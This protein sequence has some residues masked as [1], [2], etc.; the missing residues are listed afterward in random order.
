[1]NADDSPLP[2]DEMSQP[3]D[4]LAGAMLDEHAPL[5]AA[6]METLSVEQRR[7]LVD[8]QWIDALMRHGAPAEAAAVER[9][10]AG[11]LSGLEDAARPEPR[12]IAARETRVLRRQRWLPAVSLSSIA[13]AAAV[14]IALGFWWQRGVAT[15]DG[16]G[17]ALVPGGAIAA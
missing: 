9:A 14:M 8:L 7:W 13:A 17:R 15:G 16:D 1:M 2:N 5:D 3:L 11:V 6:A 4:E 10:V 12:T